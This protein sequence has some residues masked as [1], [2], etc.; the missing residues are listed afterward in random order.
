MSN[1][2]NPSEH[3]SDRHGGRAYTGNV[4]SETTE[5]GILATAIYY[6]SIPGTPDV[7]RFRRGR[8][9]YTSWSV[10][11]LLSRSLPMPRRRRFRH[12]MPAAPHLP[13][14]ARLRCVI[15]DADNVIII[16]YGIY[17]GN[18]RYR[19]GVMPYDMVRASDKWRQ[20][21]LLANRGIR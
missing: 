5:P 10:R 15:R 18:C 1:W 19:E 6:G 12:R 17:Y 8:L 20:V 4:R 13:R 14:A 21:D 9:T 2:L 3:L 7:P 11:E 16:T